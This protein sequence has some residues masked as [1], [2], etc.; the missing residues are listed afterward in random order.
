M[1]C[2]VFPVFILFFCSVRNNIIFGTIFDED[3]YQRTLEVC[4]L[5]PDLAILP[6]GDNTEIGMCLP[7]YVYMRMR[8]CARVYMDDYRIVVSSFRRSLLD[9]VYNFIL[10]VFS[11]RMRSDVYC[12]TH[13]SGDL[14]LHS[15]V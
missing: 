13:L 9:H 2:S 3:R 10:R 5:L 1:C 6:A 15:L 11:V 12:L 4:S 14:F 8:M 7:L